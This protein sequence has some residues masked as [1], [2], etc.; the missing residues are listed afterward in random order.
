[1]NKKLLLLGSFGL[2]VGF[3]ALTAFDGKSLAQQKA[4]IAQMVTMKLDELRAAKEQ[5]CTDKINAEAQRRFDE[6][7]AARAAEAAA[8]P[9]KKPPTKPKGPKPDPTPQP[10]GTGSESKDKW[11]SG[12]TQGSQDKWNKPQGDQTKPAQ[13]SE[14]KSKWQKPAGGGGK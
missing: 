3:F 9:G 5:E 6:I 14:S 10:S 13:P 12:Q 4:E 11:N 2:A 1:M 7:L 8:K